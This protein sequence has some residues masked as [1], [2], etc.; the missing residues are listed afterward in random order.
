VRR[1]AWPFL[2]LTLL[3]GAP[4]AEAAKRP[5]RA[6][7]HGNGES[8]RIGPWTYSWAFPSGPEYCAEVASDGVPSYDARID[9]A[10]P[11]ARP[12]LVIL[13]DRRPRVLRFRAHAELDNNGFTQGHGKHVT[14]RVRPKRRN[15][16]VVAWAIVF[17]VNV[18]AR[19]YFDLDLGFRPRGRCDEGGGGSY[20]FGIGHE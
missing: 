14:S 13:R 5:P 16:D 15:G 20:A 9:V 19:P 8:A 6:K 18:G 3:L 2:V 4:A 11:H 7:L 10:H 17:R 1:S 12:R